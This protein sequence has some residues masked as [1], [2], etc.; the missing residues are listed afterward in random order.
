MAMRRRKASPS[1]IQS[2]GLGR[3]REKM[4]MAEKTP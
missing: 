2:V 3:R 1:S 4:R